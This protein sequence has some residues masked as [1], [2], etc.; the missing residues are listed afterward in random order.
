MTTHTINITIGKA[1][2]AAHALAR[3]PKVTRIALA[4]VAVLLVAYIALVARTVFAGVER[5]SLIGVTRDVSASVATLEVEYL[6]LSRTF[7]REHATELGL[8]ES[9]NISYAN[10]SETLT[11]NTR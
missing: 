6:Q 2:R 3:T 7:S 4:V 11:L 5:H 10:V 8:I 9:N 1:G